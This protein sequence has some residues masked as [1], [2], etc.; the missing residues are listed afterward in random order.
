MSQE[1]GR[2]PSDLRPAIRRVRLLLLKLLNDPEDREDVLQN[3]LVRWAAA[4][5]RGVVVDSLAAFLVSVVQQEVNLW[6]RQAKRGRSVHS[7]DTSDLD[8]MSAGTPCT[9][10][11]TIEAALVS[12]PS[13][14]DGWLEDWLSGKSDAF[15]AKRDGVTCAAIRKRWQMLRENI[16]CPRMTKKILEF[17]L[18]KHGASASRVAKARVSSRSQPKPKPKPRPKSPS[19]SQAQ[20]RVRSPVLD[21]PRNLP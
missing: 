21:D 5:A 16:E 2:E 19:H 18:T 17:P 10:E 1:E 13:P 7:V 6:L 15:L 3:C 12:L 14:L 11:D 20:P 4:R 8:Q 9:G